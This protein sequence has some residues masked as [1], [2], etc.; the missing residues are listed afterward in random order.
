MPKLPKFK[1]NEDKLKY[2]LKNADSIHIAIITAKLMDL[3]DLLKTDEQKQQF[4]NEAK[5]SFVHPQVVIDA[6]DFL[7]QIL[8]P[9]N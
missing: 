6:Y 7:R 4:R 1:T 5:N 3:C 2:W 9:E 8:E